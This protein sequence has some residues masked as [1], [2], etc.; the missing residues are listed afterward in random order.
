MRPWIIVGLGAFLVLF[1]VGVLI[2][3]LPQRRAAAEQE[4]CKKNLKDLA[5]FAAMKSD[6]DPARAA[7]A[8]HEV[9]A[10]TIVLP[11]VPPS[12]RLSWVPAALP[13]FDQRH[14]KTTE[15]VE[16]IDRARPWESSRNQEAAKRKLL[17]LLCPGRPPEIAADRFAPTQ[18]VGIAGIGATAAEFNVVTKESGCFR[19]DSPTPFTD[20]ADGLSQTLLFGERSEELGPW[21]QGGPSTVRGLE[22]GPNAPLLGF[23]G[24]HPNTSNWAMADGSVRSITPRID[25]KILRSLATIAGKEQETIPGE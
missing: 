20:I 4:A 12:A 13:T 1:A 7:A 17:A 19:Y 22:A 15:I 18:Y 3:A 25:P 11:G 8:P 2:T 23:G 6:P 5:A 21:L 10:G 9:P 14:Q 16:A 24:N